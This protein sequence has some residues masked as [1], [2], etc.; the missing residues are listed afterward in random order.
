MFWAEVNLDIKRLH[1]GKA[2][3]LDDGVAAIFLKKAPLVLYYILVSLFTAFLALGWVPARWKRTVVRAARAVVLRNLMDI[4][5]RIRAW[6]R[7]VL[8]KVRAGIRPV[9][10]YT[11]LPS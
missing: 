7:T 5:G 11:H 3:G 9:C 10:W 6:I 1:R 8:N 4:S 2:P